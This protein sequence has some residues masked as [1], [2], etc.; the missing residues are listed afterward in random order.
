MIRFISK[1]ALT[2]AFSCAAQLAT[3]QT[4]LPAKAPDSS[5]PAKRQALLAS[6][7][8]LKAQNLYLSDFVTY[9]SKLLSAAKSDPA[10]VRA[11]GRRP[12]T[13]CDATPL[14]SICPLFA[15]TFATDQ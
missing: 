13:A 4:T 11:I 15:A 14:A 9:Q 10:T 3:A 1:I 5:Y 12:M 6:L 8:D 2:F 7:A